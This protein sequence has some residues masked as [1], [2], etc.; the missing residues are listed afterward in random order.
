MKRYLKKSFMLFILISFTVTFSGCWDYEEMIDVKYLAGIAVDKDKYTNDYILTLEVLEASTNSKSINSNIVESRGKTIHSAFRDAIKVTGNMLQGS[1]AKIFI[2]SKEIAEEGIIQVIDLIDRDVQLRNDMWILISES[3]TA[4]DILCKG[5][6]ENEIISYE[7]AATNANA[8]KVGKY[9]DI[10]IYRLI[11]DISN[12][13]SSAIAPLVNIKDNIGES[14]FE[15][16]GMAVFKGEKVV[17]NLDELETMFLQ[18]L[19]EDNLKFVLPIELE[20]GHKISLEIMNVNRSMNPKL[21]DNKVV[22]DMTVNIDTALSELGSSGVDYIL[23]D[24]RD[25]VK[26]QSEKQI[27]TDCYKVIEKLQKEYK[28]DAIGFGDIL[29]KRKPNAWKEMEYQWSDI[30]EDIEVNLDVNVE[31]K[32]NGVTNRNIKVGD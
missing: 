25:K 3:D 15:V 22:I 17:G 10:E 1:H 11:S 31:I 7:L 32:Y 23:K 14:K 4:A 18:I 13:G 16:S 19:K 2:V 24:E 9:I 28:S 30:F 5:K 20:D 29:K 6:R 21:K 8:N 26:I 12:L 27:V